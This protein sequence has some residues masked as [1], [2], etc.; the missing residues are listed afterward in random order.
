MVHGEIVVQCPECGSV[1]KDKLSMHLSIQH[2]YEESK[3]LKKKSELRVMYLWCRSNKHGYPLPL[4]C[5][6]CNK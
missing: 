4:P 1:I 6:D 3:S 2:K 5:T